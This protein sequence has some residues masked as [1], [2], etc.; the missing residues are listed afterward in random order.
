MPVYCSYQEW[1][2]DQKS[3]SEFYAVLKKMCIFNTGINCN[4]FIMPNAEMQKKLI[5]LGNSGDKNKRREFLKHVSALMLQIDLH[6]KRFQSG[7]YKNNLGQGVQISAPT[8]GVFEIKSGKGHSTSCKVKINTSFEPD[9]QFRSD[10][11]R[12]NCV[13]DLV[14]GEIAVDGDMF[15]GEHAKKQMEGASEIAESNCNEKLEAWTSIISSV[16]FDLENKCDAQEP[17][18][19][20]CGLLTLFTKF[21]DEVPEHKQC[22]DIVHTTLAYEPLATLYILMQP[23]SQHQLMPKRLNEE[24]AFAPH[25]CSDPKSLIEEFSAKFPCK[26][27]NDKRDTLISEIKSGIGAEKLY[28][29]QDAYSKYCS[30]LLSGINYPCEMKL[31]AD[32]VCYFICKRMCHIRKTHDKDAFIELCNTLR[33]VYPGS[34][35]M[36][37][38]RITDDKFWEGF[39]RE[40]EMSEIGDFLNSFC[41]FQCCP[42]D[43]SGLSHQCAEHLKGGKPSKYLKML[44]KLNA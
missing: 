21:C 34:D 8:S 25:V 31:W 41:C 15:T 1:L 16:L 37:E 24:W 9:L 26:V 36:K 40:K 17:T 18:F 32:E 33:E 44:V 43:K 27:D 13:V 38:S 5:S 14:S 29:L 2:K 11:D 6:D 22:A 10:D 19:R 20:L 4:T 30:D 23:Y 42:D 35:H 39:D 3:A 7:T 28:N 12:H